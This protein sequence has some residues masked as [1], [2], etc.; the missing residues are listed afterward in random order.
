MHFFSFFVL[1][2]AKPDRNMEE[3]ENELIKKTNEHENDDAEKDCP[4]IPGNVRDNLNNMNKCR[5]KLD[6]KESDLKPRKTKIYGGS[7][8]F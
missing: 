7:F 2:C 3:A 8:I 1:L 5:S 4:K 6:K